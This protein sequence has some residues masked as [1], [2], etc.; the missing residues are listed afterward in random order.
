MH[1]EIRGYQ[2]FGAYNLRLTGQRTH[3]AGE[4]GDQKPAGSELKTSEP[5]EY[6]NA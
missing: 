4:P 6:G 2:A 1:F 3:D 5:S